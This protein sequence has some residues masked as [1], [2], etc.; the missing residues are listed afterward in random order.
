MGLEVGL[1][2]QLHPLVCLLP[3]AEGK[4]N[5]TLRKLAHTRV[6]FEDFAGEIS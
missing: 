2:Q 4:L 1:T 5:L 6:R 3:G